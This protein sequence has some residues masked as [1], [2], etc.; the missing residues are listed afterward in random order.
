MDAGIAT[1]TY[2]F[3]TSNLQK[4]LVITVGLHKYSFSQKCAE[5]GT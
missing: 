3:M 5:I 1:V 4:V 2:V